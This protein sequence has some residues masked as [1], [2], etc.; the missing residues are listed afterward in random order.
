MANYVPR[1]LKEYKKAVPEIVKELELKNIMEVPRIEKIVVN[2][3]QGEA[4]QNIKVLE[5]AYTDLQALTGQKP[6]MT[7]ARKSIAGFKVRKGM[8]IGCMV[9]LRGHRMYE[10]L[11]RLINIAIPR[12]RDFRGYSVK[13]FDG[14]G[15][16]SV[17]I[18]E[19]IVFPEIDYDK[20]DKVRGLSISIGTSA[21]SDTHAKVLLEKFNFPF[22]KS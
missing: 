18:K 4:V 2:I 15:N 12:I 22:R 16:F 7:K 20:V 3:G 14:R 9:T 8:P 10:F 5:S 13:S 19:Q 21:K 17:G 6:V 1:L 11:D